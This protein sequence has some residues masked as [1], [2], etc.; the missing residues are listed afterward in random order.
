MTPEQLPFHVVYHPEAERELA[1][2]RGQQ[3]GEYT[4][5]LTA[6]D[7]LRRLV[8]RL[9]APHQ[10][11]TRGKQGRGLRELRPRRGRSRW[12]P[13]YVQATD[14]TFVVLAMAPE[15]QINRRGFDRAVRAAQQRLGEVET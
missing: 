13:I 7:K 11:G 3:L 9:L 6:L 5:V 1:E 2:V 10:S 8:P 12:R 4:A 15:A 14:T